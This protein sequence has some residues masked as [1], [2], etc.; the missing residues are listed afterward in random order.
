MWLNGKV[1]VWSRDLQ[2]DLIQ[3]KVLTLSFS[4]T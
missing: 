4:K 1:N 2:I 3:D